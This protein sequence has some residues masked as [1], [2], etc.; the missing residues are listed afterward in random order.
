VKDHPLNVSSRLV[1]VEDACKETHWVP[2]VFR[3]ELHKLLRSELTKFKS[4]MTIAL[5]VDPSPTL[6]F[7]AVI[8]RPNDS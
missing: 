5:S 7:Q 6:S 8:V 4:S 1:S 3:E 2:P